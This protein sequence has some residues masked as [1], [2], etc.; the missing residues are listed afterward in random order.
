MLF[1]KLRILWKLLL[2]LLCR[3]LALLGLCRRRRFDLVS[4]VIG[5]DRAW[6]R[7]GEILV[8]LNFEADIREELRRRGGTPYQPTDKRVTP[9]SKPSRNPDWRQRPGAPFYGDINRRMAEAGIGF[10]LW[11]GFSTRTAIRTVQKS[12][13][14]GVYFNTVYLG[15]DYY[16]GGPR[17][18]PTPLPDPHNFPT[19]TP[20]STVDI[21]VLDNGMPK[22]WKT[23]F[24]K[25]APAVTLTRPNQFSE[26][27]V[28]ENL[29]KILDKQ[30]GHGLFICGLIAQKQQG[31]DIDLTRIM[32]A[33]GDVDVA[34]ASTALGE[35]NAKVVNMSFGGY[36]PNNVVHPAMKTAVDNAVGKD[37]VLVAAAGNDGSGSPDYNRPFWPAALDNVIAVGAYEP[38]AS[39]PT[40]WPESNRAEVY[41][42]G[43][44]IHS[45]YVKDWPVPANSLFNS[46]TSYQ[47]WAKWSGTSFAAPLVAADIADK[48]KAR[49][50]GTTARGEAVIW[51]KSLPEVSNWPHKWRP[52]GVPTTD[53][54]LFVPTP[55]LWD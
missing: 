3:F 48:V 35:S 10:R 20:D 44:N 13:L 8:D 53:P 40:L 25:L 41:A 30:A 33:T 18:L 32:H 43:V 5:V 9:D 12:G 4:P 28:D 50:A 39:G 34:L 47:G 27:P 54:R 38:S 52:A 23:H 29:D 11:V 7:P 6:V 36:S 46:S 55:K 31:L 15:E 45:T 21:T 14:P 1:V 37:Q 42:P 2:S 17:G 16:Q 19:L 22:D 51:L 24:P 49:P 26:D